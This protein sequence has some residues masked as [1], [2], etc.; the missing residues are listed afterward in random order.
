[1]IRPSQSE[2][3]LRTHEK[4]ARPD[5]VGLGTVNSSEW[6][7]RREGVSVPDYVTKEKQ[8]LRFYAYFQEPVHEGGSMDTTGFRVRKFSIM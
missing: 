5:T 4:V 3:L 2:P 6:R 8:V 7:V 1:M